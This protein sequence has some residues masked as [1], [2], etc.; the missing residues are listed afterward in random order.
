MKKTSLFIPIVFFCLSTLV[1]ASQFVSSN[2]SD[3][4]LFSNQA[5]VVREGQA[6][7]K[8]GLNELLIETSAF[9]VDK[10]SISAQVFGNGE[11]LSVQIQQI[12]LVEFPQDQINTLSE[13]LRKLKQSRKGLSDKK[14]VLA[15][16][17]SFIDGLIDFSKTQ[18]PK[19]VQTRYPNMEDVQET[20]SFIGSTS[21][22]IYAEIQT[23]DIALENMDREIVKVKKELAAVSGRSR[24]SKQIIEILFNATQE[25]TARLNVQYLVKG[26]LWQPLY[27]VSV[28]MNL[29]VLDLTMFARITQKSGEDWKK[30]AL[31][32]SNVIPVKGVRF[33]EISPWKLDLPRPVPVLLKRSQ[34]KVMAETSS[35]MELDEEIQPVTGTPAEYSSATATELPLSFEYKMPFPVDIDSRDQFSIL[36]LLTKNLSADTFHYSI[37]GK[38]NLTFLVADARADKELLAGKLNVYFGGR[39]IGDT[40]LSE[41]KPGEPFSLNLG[42]DRNVMVHRKKLKDK[43]KETYFGT[44]QRGTVVRSFSY[45]ITAENIKDKPITL[46]IVDRVPVSKTDKIEVKDIQLTPAPTES[47]YHDKEGVHLWVFQLLP[48]ETQE[49]DLDFT[50]AY[51]AEATPFGL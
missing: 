8:L 3:V 21:T 26:A 49:I 7:L 6:H 30:I 10:D 40:Y 33:P 16:K 25:E 18:I 5:M 37:P 9:N 27:K 51:P 38:T 4:T 28:P 36:P 42:A 22:V 29:S 44:I 1:H 46:K 11:M 13:T 14:L 48:G 23:L 41:K 47:N 43:V 19:D 32:V 39:F 12:P 24:A 17:E 15:K 35:K 34:A 31:S 45:K 50:V 2:I 20:L